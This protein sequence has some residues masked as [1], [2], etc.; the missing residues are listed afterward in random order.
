MHGWREVIPYEEVRWTSSSSTIVHADVRVMFTVTHDDSDPK[1]NAAAA[2]HAHLTSHTLRQH[3]ANA[4]S[5]SAAL[6]PSHG[7]VAGAAHVGSANPNADSVN[8]AHSHGYQHAV[9][10]RRLGEP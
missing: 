7:A 4:S 2:A 10:K 9:R 1:L 5:A 3:T 8:Q 6:R